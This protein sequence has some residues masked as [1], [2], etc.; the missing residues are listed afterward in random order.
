MAATLTPENGDVV[1][2]QKRGDPS[3]VYLLGTPS[4]PD[5]FTLRTRDEAVSQALAFA[6]RQQVRAWFANGT[7]EFVLLGTFRK[8]NVEPARSS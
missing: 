3:T 7:D 4:T 6:K 1:V 8:D 2:R 5:Q